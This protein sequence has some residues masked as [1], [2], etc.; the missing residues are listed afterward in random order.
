[1]KTTARTIL[2][3]ALLFLA[4]ADRPAQEITEGI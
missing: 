1:M 3:A 4:A 2:S